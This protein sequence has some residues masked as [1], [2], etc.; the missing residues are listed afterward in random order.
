MYATGK[1]PK[2]Q[3]TAKTTL[4]YVGTNSI[5]NKW[6]YQYEVLVSAKPLEGIRWP[7][8]IRTITANA[9]GR[10]YVKDTLYGKLYSMDTDDGRS[11][12]PESEF[13]G[14]KSSEK[15]SLKQ[16]FDVLGIRVLK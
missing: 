7:L 9:A 13:A 15:T 5:W 10:K 6:R 16:E 4:W 8:R 12:V 1:K 14:K 3:R 11:H 2:T